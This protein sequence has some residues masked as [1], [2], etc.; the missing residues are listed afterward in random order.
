[1]EGSDV[2]VTFE[3]GSSDGLMKMVAYGLNGGLEAL[4]LYLY[5][6]KTNTIFAVRTMASSI[7]TISC[8][9]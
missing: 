7:L 8:I 3:D 2:P 1:M 5:V 9:G 6:N 4:K